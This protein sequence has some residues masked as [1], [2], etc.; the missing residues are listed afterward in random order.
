MIK[1]NV[2]STELV[3]NLN[4]HSDQDY[5]SAGFDCNNSEDGDDDNHDNDDGDDDD[6]NI[7]NHDKKN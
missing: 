7:N 1:N 2:K 5:H 3:K 6:K 4:S